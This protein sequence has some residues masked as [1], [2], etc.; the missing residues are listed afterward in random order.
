MLTH[1]NN[2][3]TILNKQKSLYCILDD[4]GIEKEEF[5]LKDQ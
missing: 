1:S 5:R 3:G 4:Y 2:S